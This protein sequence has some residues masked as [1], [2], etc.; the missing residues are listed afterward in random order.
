MAASIGALTCF[1]TNTMGCIC[2]MMA[3]RDEL[4]VFWRNGQ[5][6]VS[7]R[8]TVRSSCDLSAGGM[9]LNMLSSAS[10]A[11]EVKRYS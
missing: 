9:L 4:V 5:R 2:A 1:G 10:A 3:M 8:L 11:D 6:A 7:L